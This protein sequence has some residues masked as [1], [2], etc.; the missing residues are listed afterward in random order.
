MALVSNGRKRGEKCR[1]FSTFQDLF[2]IISDSTKI[3]VR[4]RFRNSE[5][6][7]KMSPTF[8]N[9]SFVCNVK[10]STDSRRS[11]LYSRHSGIRS[12]TFCSE[13]SIITVTIIASDGIHNS[14]QWHRGTTVC[15]K[16]ANG[17]V[18]VILFNLEILDNKTIR[19][20]AKSCRC[21]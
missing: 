2:A 11:S 19:S 3:N 6:D 13:D 16:E 10:R 21:D 8:D 4:F 17:P 1:I 14:K 7:F 5:T 12:K 9:F 18:F 20:Y 15:R